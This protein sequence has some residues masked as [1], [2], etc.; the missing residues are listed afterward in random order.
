MFAHHT[1]SNHKMEATAG[2]IT[3]APDLF[4]PNSEY[5]LMGWYNSR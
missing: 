3:C 4:C 1:E 5:S 2:V